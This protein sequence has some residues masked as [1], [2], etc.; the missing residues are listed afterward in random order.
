M[1][2]K[3]SDPNEIR[4]IAEQL[5]AE[6]NTFILTKEAAKVPAAV[7]NAEDVCKY[8]NK[9]NR[10]RLYQAAGTGANAMVYLVKAG[11]YPVLKL[12][13]DKDTKLYSIEDDTRDID[14]TDAYSNIEPLGAD[15]VWIGT[16][17]KLNSYLTVE[18]ARR[19]NAEIDMTNY[20][21]SRIAKAIELG[22]TPTSNTNMLHTLQ[23]IITQMLGES[24][25][26]HNY[27][28]TS[29]DVNYL[30]DVYAT[31]D[32]KIRGAVKCPSHKEFIT[33]LADVCYRIVTGR[34][35][36]AI[37]SK[38]FKKPKQN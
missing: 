7:E 13:Q 33:S 34:K 27:K 24:D 9:V 29:H 30:L 4:T 10:L 2:I 23:T 17:Q 18:A 22:E 37:T 6:I 21:L 1:F 16:A 26:E 32:K 5:C 14:L 11:Y 35:G 28:A 31:R 36:Y 20:H 38:N 3:S 19:V 25:E 8:Y 15:P 12:K